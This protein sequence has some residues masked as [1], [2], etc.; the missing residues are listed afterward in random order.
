MFGRGDNEDFQLK[1]Y[2]IAAH[3]IAEMK[4]EP[5]PYKLYFFSSKWRRG[6]SERFVTPAR[7]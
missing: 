3:A 7:H 4:D 6:E 1:G 2:D 5:Q